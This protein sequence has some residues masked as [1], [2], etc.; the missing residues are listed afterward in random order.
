MSDEKNPAPDPDPNAPAATTEQPPAAKKKLTLDI[1]EVDTSEVL[2][3]K[4]SA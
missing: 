2:E 3:R 4:I 1:D